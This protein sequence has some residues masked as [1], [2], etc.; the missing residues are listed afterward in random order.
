MRR[1][2][3][4]SRLSDAEWA[5]LAHELSTSTRREMSVVGQCALRSLTLP[6]R[7]GAELRSARR[8]DDG[9]HHNNTPQRRPRKPATQYSARR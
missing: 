1:I 3:Y 4:P 7:G 5:L 2:S 8:E 6:C 9:D